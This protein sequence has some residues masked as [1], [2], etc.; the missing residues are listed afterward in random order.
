MGKA[1]R[2]KAVLAFLCF[3]LLFLLCGCWD[4]RGLNEIAIVAGMAI[5]MDPVS[6][7]F[8]VA[9]EIVDLTNVKSSGPKSKLVE[10]TGKTVFDAGRNAK[11]RLEKR[12]YYGNDQI[13]IISEAIAKSG[14]LKHIIDWFL[15]DAEL[16]ETVHVIVSREKTAAELLS[17]KGINDPIV[18]YEIEKMIMDDNTSTSS[19]NTILLYQVYDTLHTEGL[20]L[21]LP[22]LHKVLNS[23]EMTDEINGVAVFKG[24]SMLGYLTPE[25]SKYFL[26]VI[27]KVKGGV[28]TLPANE[29][30]K[31]D[32]SLEISQNSTK[33]SYTVEDGKLKMMIDTETRVYLDEIANEFD[34]LDEEEVTSLEA[35]A[36]AKLKQEMEGVIKKVQTEYGSDIFGFGNTIRKKNIKL[37]SSVS[38]NWDM[39]FPTLQVTVNAKVTIAN[40]AYIKDTKQEGK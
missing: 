33:Q 24:E 29:G 39:L 17:V 3:S 9:Y 5:D 16:R 11:K 34:A 1:M 31:D 37:W 25:E 32:V 14:H 12:L 21:A 28:L 6:G 27:N 40:S 23:Q 19:T 15:R 4:Y 20:S 7:D 22:V 38:G 26:F 30:E 10:S 18:S 2:K 13:L 35:A 8:K 36:G